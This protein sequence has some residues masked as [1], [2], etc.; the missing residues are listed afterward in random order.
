MNIK[1][2]PFKFAYFTYDR[3][4]WKALFSIYWYQSQEIWGVGAK[5]I[6][7]KNLQENLTTLLRPRSSIGTKTDSI[8]TASKVNMPL[9]LISKHRISTRLKIYIHKENT[10]KNPN[11]SLSKVADWQYGWDTMKTYLKVTF[12]DRIV[13][14]KTRYKNLNYNVGSSIRKWESC[15]DRENQISPYTTTKGHQI[16]ICTSWLHLKNMNFVKSSICNSGRFDNYWYPLPSN[17]PHSFY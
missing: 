4:T 12:G 6:K 5:T 1:H 15:W 8:K 17:Y 11:S 10:V 7:S 9:L 14:L 3:A 16:H 13:F 2:H